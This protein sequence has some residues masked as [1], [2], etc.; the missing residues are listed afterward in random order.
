MRKSSYALAATSLVAA[1]TLSGDTA[2]TRQPAVRDRPDQLGRD[3][4][5]RARYRIVRREAVSG[6][7]ADRTAPADPAA[8]LAPN[9][10]VPATAR[11]KALSDQLAK[12]MRDA[13][14]KARAIYEYLVDSGTYDKTTPRLGKGRLRALL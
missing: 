5:V 4:E 3:V 12:G 7:L 13:T 10:L 1:V 11:V 9:R 2:V 14:E 6:A 8:F